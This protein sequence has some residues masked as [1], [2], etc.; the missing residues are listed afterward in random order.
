[1]VAG[2]M[3]DGVAEIKD[4]KIVE[5]TEKDLERLSGG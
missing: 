3:E 5:A 1:M 2:D 4:E